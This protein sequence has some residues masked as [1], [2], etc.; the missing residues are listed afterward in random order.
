LPESATEKSATA[1][2]HWLASKR[3]IF[4]ALACLVLWGVFGFLSK[5]G[6]GHLGAGQMQVIFTCGTL[7]LLLPA[8]WRARSVSGRDRA[9]LALAVATGAI[10]ALANVALFAALKRGPASVVT[11]ATALYPMITFLLA[12]TLLREK[13]NACQYAGVVLALISIFLFSL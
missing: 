2:S 11:P 10:A 4:G 7:P 6:A 5:L 3:W 1:R 8:W 13:M 9:G 12:R